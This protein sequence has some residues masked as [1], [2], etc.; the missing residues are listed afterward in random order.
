[1][2]FVSVAGVEVHYVE[3]GEA[4]ADHTFVGLHGFGGDHR[5]SVGVYEPVFASR[6]GWRRLY[7]DFP[8]MGKTK[9]PESVASAD[10]L[11][12]ITCGAVDALVSGRYALSGES[13]GGYI[14]M[15]L[16]AAS[17]DQIT[18]LAL[19]VPVV[20]PI[21]EDRALPDHVVLYR[22]PGVTGSA[23]SEEAAVVLTAEVLRRTEE[24]FGGTEFA[25]DEAALE[26]IAQRYAGTFPIPTAFA[27]PALI[28]VGRQ[29]SVVG[30]ED[31][32]RLLN[33]WPR[34]TIAVLDRAGHNLEIEQNVLVTAL[35]S[36]WL[37]RVLDVY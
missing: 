9:A 19:T 32:V 13:Y 16:A 26:R 15:G 35:I 31:Q 12:R 4:A 5:A 22:E 24:H 1:M 7:F 14:A 33:H 10:D 2:P 18:G 20:L 21:R 27:G 3:H 28:A 17:P 6:P 8:G 25:A 29:D 36:E 34:A 11:F 30:F 23:E 37:D